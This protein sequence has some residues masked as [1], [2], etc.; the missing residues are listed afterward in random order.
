MQHPKALVYC[1]GALSRLRVFAGLTLG[2]V[3][4][5]YAEPLAQESY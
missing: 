1:A 5:A 3:I 2:R 4:S